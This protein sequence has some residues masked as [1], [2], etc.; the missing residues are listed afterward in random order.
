MFNNWKKYSQ[1]K[2]EE[3]YESSTLC[4]VNEGSWFISSLDVYRLK[5]SKLASLL[6]K[7]IESNTLN[8]IKSKKN[9][10]Q[11]VD[12]YYFFVFDC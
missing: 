9:V 10:E 6:G 1:S 4:S 2:W 3:A 7:C 5:F 11:P 8:T 12:Y